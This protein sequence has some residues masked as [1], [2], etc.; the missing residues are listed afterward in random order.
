MCVFV[1]GLLRCGAR[2]HV[3]VSVRLCEWCVLYVCRVCVCVRVCVP[4]LFRKKKASKKV[5]RD[6]VQGAGLPRKA[7]PSL[8]FP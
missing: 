2:G 6:V 3:L 1:V 4:C 8:E 5:P 7:G